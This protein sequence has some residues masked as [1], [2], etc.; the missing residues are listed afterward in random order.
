MIYL[1][2]EII[3]TQTKRKMYAVVK[4]TN[5]RKD[6]DLKVLQTFFDKENAIKQAHEYAIQEFGES[7][8]VDEVE[9]QWFYLYDAIAEYTESDGTLV[10]AVILLPNP[11]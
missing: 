10:F 11:E 3:I 9:E 7:K 2:N 8:V 1:I 5:Y 6:I 4:Y